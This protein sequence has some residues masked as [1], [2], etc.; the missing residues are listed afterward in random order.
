MDVEVDTAPPQGGVAQRSQ[1]RESKDL[2]QRPCCTLLKQIL[3]HGAMQTRCL[4]TQEIHLS[5][6]RKE[7]LEA[8]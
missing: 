2:A 3:P 7:T 8:C 4:Y 6:I 5:T 1:N